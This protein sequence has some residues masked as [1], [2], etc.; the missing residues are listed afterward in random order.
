MDDAS[1]PAA[2]AAA[3]LV[4]PAA[5][6]AAAGAA[7][8]AA[9]SV[10]GYGYEYDRDKSYPCYVNGTLVGHHIHRNRI[11]WLTNDEWYN[12]PYWTRLSKWEHEQHFP[13]REAAL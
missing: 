7:S 9:G 1:D 5:V 10:A 8:D 6:D 11:T 4:L 12:L 13:P 2:D 3:G